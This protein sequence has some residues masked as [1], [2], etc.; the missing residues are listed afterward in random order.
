MTPEPEQS[1]SYTATLRHGPMLGES[2]T[3]LPGAMLGAVGKAPGSIPKAPQQSP[4]LPDEYDKCSNAEAMERRPRCL[5]LRLLKAPSKVN[6]VLLEKRL[7]VA[8]QVQYAVVLS[9]QPAIL[10]P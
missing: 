4:G 7:L 9:R 8:L 2:V 10:I 6:A 5:E 3:A 1:Q